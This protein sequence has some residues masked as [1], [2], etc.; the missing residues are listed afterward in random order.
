MS[1]ASPNPANGRPPSSAESR[2]AVVTAGTIIVLS[3]IA[4]GI[5]AWVLLGSSAMSVQGYI[6]LALGIIAT[7]ALG[8][9]LMALV[10]FSNRYGYDERVGRGTEGRGG[11]RPR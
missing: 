2:R 3:I 6:A 8:V 9:G 5:Y 11:D 7:L 4:V 1:G 10:F